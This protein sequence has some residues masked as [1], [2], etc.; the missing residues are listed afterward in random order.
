MADSAKRNAPFTGTLLSDLISPADGVGEGQ[1]RLTAKDIENVETIFR[2]GRIGYAYL[3]PHG[4]EIPQVHVMNMT[5]ENIANFIGQHRGDSS[6]MTLTDQLDVTIL[7]TYGEFIDKCPDKELLRD[8]LQYLVPIQMGEAA[9]KNIP[10]VTM[11]TY[12]LYDEFLEA[13]QMEMTMG[14]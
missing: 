10:A 3:Y 14:M 6:E 9:P 2:T 8:V 7:T 5:P 13:T 11:D 1:D 4:R 12:E